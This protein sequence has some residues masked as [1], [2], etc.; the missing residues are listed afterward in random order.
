MDDFSKYEAMREQGA[1]P[2]QVY[3][4]AAADGL[5]SITLI[6]LIRRVCGLTLAQAKIVIT[7]AA[8]QDDQQR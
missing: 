8:R 2:D 1:T 7:A 3:A 6:R 5:D 4:A